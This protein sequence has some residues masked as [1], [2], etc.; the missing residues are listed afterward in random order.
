MKNTIN[1]NWRKTLYFF[2]LMIISTSAQAQEFPIELHCN[3]CDLFVESMAV[4]PDGDIYVTGRTGRYNQ[5]IFG[6]NGINE[7][8]SPSYAPYI[9]NYDIFIARFHPDS[10]PS[11]NELVWLVVGRTTAASSPLKHSGKDIEVDASGNAYV[12]GSMFGN[13]EFERVFPTPLSTIPACP[14]SMRH[15]VTKINADGTPDWVADVKPTTVAETFGEAIALDE[16][17]NRIITGGYASVNAASTTITMRN[18]DCT[19]QCGFTAV[20]TPTGNVG[21]ISEYTLSGMNYRVAGIGE[22]VMALTINDSYPEQIWATGSIYNTDLDV[23]LAD[24]YMDFVDEP[25]INFSY[26]LMNV[27]GVGDDIGLDIDWENDGTVVLT[28]AFTTQLTWDPTPDMIWTIA[29]NTDIFVG[30]ISSGIMDFTTTSTIPD[31]AVSTSLPI[32]YNKRSS[33]IAA[34]RST[35]FSRIIIGY[36]ASINGHLETQELSTTL[37]PTSAV[38]YIN[39]VA[40]GDFARAMEIDYGVGGSADKRFLA[41]DFSNV[42]GGGSGYDFGPGGVIGALG[43]YWD[44]YV[45]RLDASHVMTALILGTDELDEAIGIELFPNPTEGLVTLRIDMNTISIKIV[46]NKG[47]VLIEREGLNAGEHSL[48]LNGLTP[49]FYLLEINSTEGNFTRKLIVR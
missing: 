40:S 4:G 26:N 29:G 37:A 46:D 23:M 41:G 6:P 14:G 13:V 9:S 27:S 24:V 16:A 34:D 1:L 25:C 21:F 15:F 36:D 10:I 7:V 35:P 8:H 44:G 32:P 38:Q 39:P 45:T 49:G 47:G 11:D 17:N 31:G 43:T 18:Q 48:N 3:G 12:V 2:T 22:R 42:F 20:P 19:D 28:G 5:F 30:R 33:C